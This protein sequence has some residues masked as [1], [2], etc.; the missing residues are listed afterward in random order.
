MFDETR[1]DE[2]PPPLGDARAGDCDCCD[3]VGIGEMGEM[4]LRG[5]L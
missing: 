3:A 4:F 2:K 5:T 1:Q